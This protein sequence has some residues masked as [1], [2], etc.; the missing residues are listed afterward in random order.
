MDQTFSWPFSPSRYTSGLYL[1]LRVPYQVLR[2]SRVPG[3]V[4]R[5]PGLVLRVPDIFLVLRGFR[6][7]ELFL[8]FKKVFKHFN[9]FF[10]KK[11]PDFLTFSWFQWASGFYWL[12]CILLIIPGSPDYSGFSWLFQ[13]LLII[14]GSLVYSGF[15]WLF[16]V[17]LI[18]L[19]SPDYSELSALF[20]FSWLFWILLIISGSHY[21]PEFFTVVLNHHGFLSSFRFS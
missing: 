6:V 17:L 13:V 12:S 21:I 2:V 11:C 9:V 15:S 19:N 1:V 18:I 4:L 3:L 5:V 10:I 14:P 16:Q 7:F 8:D 20:V